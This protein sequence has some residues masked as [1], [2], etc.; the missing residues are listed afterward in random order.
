[1][2]FAEESEEEQ[3]EEPEEEQESEEENRGELLTE[4][5]ENPEW[6]AKDCW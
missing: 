4:Q 6:I 5:D 1:M 2:D 3:G